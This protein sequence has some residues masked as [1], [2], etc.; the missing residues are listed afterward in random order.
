MNK[1][2]LFLIFLL[3]LCF[4]GLQLL[5][6]S[7]N[8]GPIDLQ[9]KLREVQ[10]NF[11]ATD[12]SLLG[13]G[14][15][16]DELTFKIWTKDNLTNYPWTGGA[17]LQDNN[18]TPTAGGTNSIDFNTT[19]ANFSFPTTTVPQSL[20]FKIDAWED[21]LPSDNL[22]GFCNTG[23]ACTWQGIQCC[24][25]YLFGFCIGIETGDDYRCDA[26]PFFQGL[27][28]RSGPP[29][30]WY[31]H[32]YINGSGC[33]NSNIN[34]YYKPHIETFWRYTKG[35]SFANA[36]DLGMLIFLFK[37]VLLLRQ[38]FIPTQYAESL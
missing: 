20:E 11:A 23:T 32:G 33:S 36:I 2:L 7:Y 34:G 17:C 8:D 3:S 29:C 31:S 26:D 25:V 1:Q 16:P 18:F 19:F 37:Q 27:A 21:D 38:N 13:I 5:A 24:G 12:E 35:T 28:Y 30:Q 4:D 6:Q 9:V 22:L 15:A 10:G 14:F